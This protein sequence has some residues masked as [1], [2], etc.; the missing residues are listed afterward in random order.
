VSGQFHAQVAS[1]PGRQKKKDAGWDIADLDISEKRK[2][3]CPR[4][5]PS[6]PVA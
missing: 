3:L 6:Q 4:R 2:I 1:F 5:K